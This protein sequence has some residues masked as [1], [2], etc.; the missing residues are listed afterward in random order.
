MAANTRVADDPQGT[1]SRQGQEHRAHRWH[2]LRIMA[3]GR[4]MLVQ[5]EPQPEY[6]IYIV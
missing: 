6:R 3:I 1:R 5:E 2:R 4:A